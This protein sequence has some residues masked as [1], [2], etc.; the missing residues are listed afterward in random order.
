MYIDDE[1]DKTIAATV[2]DVNNKA[3]DDNYH[4]YCGSAR[5]GELNKYYLR[6]R[7]KEGNTAYFEY[8]KIDEDAV[9]FKFYILCTRMKVRVEEAYGFVE[10]SDKV[11]EI[12]TFL[13]E[14][15]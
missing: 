10:I 8:K 6:E 3:V 11:K 1:I 15:F 7:G 5:H 4:F 2:A 14:K 12:T 9:Q 13:L